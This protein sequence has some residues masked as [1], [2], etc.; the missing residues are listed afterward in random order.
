[1]AN[2]YSYDLRIKALELIESGNKTSN[3]AKMLKIS[4][5]ALTEWKKLKRLTG[6]VKPKT[7]WKKGHSHKIKDLEAFKKFVGANAHLTQNQMAEKWG[8]V[9]RSVIGRALKKIDYTKKKDLW[10]R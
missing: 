1:M 2:P 7:N 4:R 9:T 3:V 6:N 10:I 5:S 8:N